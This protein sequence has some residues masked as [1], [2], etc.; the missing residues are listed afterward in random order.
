MMAN[1][2][3]EVLF[4]AVD[5]DHPIQFRLLFTPLAQEQTV[6]LLRDREIGYG[7][8]FAFRKSRMMNRSASEK[9]V[10]GASIRIA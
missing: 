7:D 8:D 5:R 9:A 1:R 10:C 2:A 6:K 4:H 3:F